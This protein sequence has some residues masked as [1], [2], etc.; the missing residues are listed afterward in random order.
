VADANSGDNIQAADF[1]S[2]KQEGRFHIDV[3]GVG[4]SWPF[5][6]AYGAYSR[7]FYLTMRSFY[8]QRC[9]TAVDL[10]PEFPGYKHE[11]CHTQ[12]AYH[13]TSGRSGVKAAGNKG[14]H[15]AGDYGRYVVNSGLST[16]TLLWTYEMFTDRVKDV[17]LNL[18]ESGNGVPDI[19]N[20]IRWNLD[21]MLSMQDG[22]GGVFHKQ[23]S[24][25]FCDFVMPETDGLVSYVIGTGQEPYKSSC[26]TADFAAVMSI[27]ARIYK[28]FDGAYAGKALD[29]ARR[30]FA[31]VEKNP[32][33]LFNNPKGISTG[34]YGDRAC[35]D[36]ILWAAGELWRTTRESAYQ[37]YFED[38]YAAALPRIN[39]SGPPS[40]PD[41]APVALWTYVLGGAT[42]GP[43]DA[44]R[45][46]SMTA[47]DEIVRRTA[48]DGYRVSLS[49]NDYIWG[50]NGVAANYGLQLIVANALQPN[51][52]Y[53]EAAADNLHY[54]LGRN[55]FSLSWVTQVGAN[56][57]RH[58]H[59]RPSGADGN[60]EPW[61]GLLSGG[62]NRSRQDPAMSKLPDLP[63]A[64]M[65]LDDQES[66]A[67][68]E[69]AINWN[70][71][72]VFLLADQ[73][74]KKK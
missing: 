13:A 22:D 46:A 53:R 74:P 61:P 11:A 15:D 69:I 18:P 47:A 42:G 25:R 65:Y 55:T 29:S 30:A 20:E 10:G 35:S 28:P 54:L 19:L 71:P 23:T 58:P 9:G 48:A 37:Q 57:F 73:L 41:V 43:A 64:K 6:I 60:P 70:A 59:H 52:R 5:A 17:R 68:N 63:P 32:A 26:A 8:G 3:P 67:T 2:L 33:V 16:G 56:P 24:E 36:E 1:S 21:W 62:P 4:V 40:W 31:W 66:Y 12:N 34:A 50:S 14:W 38:H 49:R 7:A 45:T 72:L 27:A 44:I 39:P 51:A